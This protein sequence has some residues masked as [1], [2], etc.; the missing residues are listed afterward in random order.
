METK[1]WKWIGIPISALTLLIK[2]TIVASI[3]WLGVYLTKSTLPYQQIWKNVIFAQLVFSLKGYFLLYI[4]LFNSDFNLELI[5]GYHPL[6]LTS[7]FQDENIETYLILIFQ[8]L[9]LFEVA[10]W[11]LLAYFLS[12]ELKGTFNDGLKVVVSSYIPAF[13]LWLIT[14]TF[15]L[16]S[17]S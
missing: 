17:N 7:L 1:K 14:V 3:I 4:A 11:F 10:Y 8:S 13:T 5:Y 6:S 12:K 16:V 2:T 9:N 15:F